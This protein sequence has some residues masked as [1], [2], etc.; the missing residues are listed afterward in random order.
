MA[1][2]RTFWHY[3]IT[4]TTR[5]QFVLDYAGVRKESFTFH[6][7]GFFFEDSLIIDLWE[8][9]LVNESTKLV[10]EMSRD[11][12]VAKFLAEEK[13]NI[14]SKTSPDGPPDWIIKLRK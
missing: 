12:S 3:P 11:L 5:H 13:L 8:N 14:F 9:Q 10:L 2:I 4:V 6:T 1:K 7:T